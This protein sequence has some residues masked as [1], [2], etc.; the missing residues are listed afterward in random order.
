MSAVTTAA[1][2]VSFFAIGLTIIAAASAEAMPRHAV[3]VAPPVVVGRPAFYA[4]LWGPWYPYP[5]GYAYTDP[6]APQASV[7][8]EVT[9]KDAQVYV[10]GYYAGE[11]REFDGVFKHL[12]VSPGGHT[13]TLY[14]DGFRTATQDVYVR[15][16]ST[17]T[18]KAT[19]D[20]LVAGETSAPVP[21]PVHERAR[22]RPSNT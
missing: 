1:T 9:P 5:Y 2:R 18:L 15:P 8:T 21:A 20:H 14:L 13:I 4:S 3:I 17:F 11:A 6:S 7:K 16:D 10:D 12:N 22:L 19:M